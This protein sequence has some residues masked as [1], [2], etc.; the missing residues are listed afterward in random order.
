MVSNTEYKNKKPR[1]RCAIEPEKFVNQEKIC[2]YC[3]SKDAKFKFLNNGN[4]NQPRYKCLSCKQFYTN[5]QHGRPRGRKYQKKRNID[6]PEWQGVDRTCKN[7]ECGAQN[8]SRFLYYN[9]N[10]KNQ[11]RFFCN[12]CGMEFQLYP[13]RQQPSFNKLANA[14]LKEDHVQENTNEDNKMFEAFVENFIGE[15]PPANSFPNG[16]HIVD[17]QVENL[18]DEDPPKKS[19]PNGVD[20]VGTQVANL[21]DQDL[22]RNSSPNGVDINCRYAS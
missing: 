11:P 19:L 15:D 22:P 13:K 17:M 3:N 9:N 18:L 4:E 14:T 5:V 1:R 8:N 10:N 6:P 12:T 7:P 20:I 2:P 16:G 21:L